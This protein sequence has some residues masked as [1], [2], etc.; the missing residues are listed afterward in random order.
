[1]VVNNHKVLNIYKKERIV[2]KFFLQLLLISILME[3]GLAREAE[4]T[5]LIIDK[6][7]EQIV[8]SVS[9]KNRNIGVLFLKNN[10]RMRAKLAYGFATFN[11]KRPIKDSD[12]F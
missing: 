6:K 12:L 11:T 7:T 9:D 1:M 8:K 2:F 5:V 3:V 4:K 10:N